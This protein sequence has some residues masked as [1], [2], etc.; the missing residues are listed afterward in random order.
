MKE[1][2]TLDE[3]T[4][5]KYKTQNEALKAFL[6][7]GYRQRDVLRLFSK[8]WTISVN[9]LNVNLSSLSSVD[10]EKQKKI[11]EKLFGKNAAS[12]TTFERKVVEWK[13][14]FDDRKPF[15]TVSKA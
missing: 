5:R 2:L 7:A 4:M 10:D 12:V 3:K 8:T 6:E 1:K 14:K 11:V 13:G 15:P 9:R